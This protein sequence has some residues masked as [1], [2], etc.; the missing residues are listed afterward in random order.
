VLGRPRID[1]IQVRFLP[2][3]NALMANVLADVDVT[4]G[5]ALSFELGLSVRDQWT[6][7]RMLNRPR[8][9]TLIAAQSVNTSPP[10]VREVNFRRALLLGLDR[11]Q[12]VDA[13]F[14]GQSAIAHS[15]VN[16][17]EPD[18]R[19]VEPKVV[20]YDYDPRRAAQLIEGLGYTKRGDGLF[21]D[22]SGQTP[23][24]S[25]WT[26]V[27]NAL[28]PKAMA[29]VADQWQRLGV[30]VEQV[31][32]PLQ[33]MRDREYRAQFPSFELV[34]NPNSLAVRDV[35]RF[36]GE[37]APLPENRFTRTGNYA[38]YQNP[39]LDAMI[40][41]YSITIPRRERMEAL[42]DVVHH[43]T[44][45]LPQM[46]IFYGQDATMVSNRLVNVT[47]RSNS[48]T[49]SWNAEQWDLQQ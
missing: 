32:V 5:N 31:P 41:R 6:E 27:S 14:A 25:I 35:R 9:W 24:I 23:S 29:A 4:L 20:R 48:F 34:E 36:H 44:E 46:P 45:N 10:I 12:L 26:T 38:R 47:A 11:Q 40:D 43:L 1:E 8:N 49:Q 39:E 7:G 22:A 2:D 15:F 13:L 19:I 21:A 30:P 37:Q 17:N 28:Q 3:S 42:G 16:P 18:Y 33:R